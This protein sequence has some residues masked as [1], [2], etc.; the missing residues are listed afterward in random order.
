MF[1]C[2]LRQ[3]STRSRSGGSTRVAR[4]IKVVD[5]NVHSLQWVTGASGSSRSTRFVVTTW[6]LTGARSR[7]RR[8]HPIAAEARAAFL[9]AS[10]SAADAAARSGARWHRRATR[11]RPDT[12]AKT[13]QRRW[14]DRDGQWPAAIYRSL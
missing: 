9:A 4:G 5:M 6:D 13:W 8:P 10:L 11:W 7:Y 14:A 2:R 12:P 3:S 1:G